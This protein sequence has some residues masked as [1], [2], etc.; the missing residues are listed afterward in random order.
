MSSC[1]PIRRA[2]GTP[3]AQPISP[4][5]SLRSSS[6]A[7]SF[8]SRT[9]ASTPSRRSSSAQAYAVTWTARIGCSGRRGTTV[10]GTRQRAALPAASV[11]SSSS[12]RGA[13][14]ARSSKAPCS[15]SSIRLPSCSSRAPGSIR[16]RS[17]RGRPALTTAGPP[18]S[19]VGAVVST[20]KRKVRS[21][22]VK[23]RPLRRTTSP[24]APSERFVGRTTARPF[25]T[26]GRT[27]RPSS[28]H[29]VPRAL[30]ANDSSVSAALPMRASCAGPV[31]VS[32]GPAAFA[33][34]PA[35]ATPSTATEATSTA[36]R[37]GRFR[38]RSTRARSVPPGGG[39][40]SSGSDGGSMRA[41]RRSSS[42]FSAQR[43]AIARPAARSSAISE[44]ARA[45]AQR[46][47]SWRLSLSIA[48]G[49]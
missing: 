29:S 42:S 49:E 8:R 45:A 35:P 48:S 39:D 17:S 32:S 20:V 38:L 10:T 37:H 13:G 18:T 6:T 24:W 11:A 7:F 12:L 26:L 33:A 22:L 40:P 36:R 30:D 23:K 5:S 28:S 15:S 3:E 31:T 16:P 41:R 14:D 34:T 43:V 1:A 47:S 19:S 27:G 4:D 44:R 25:R 21:A 2:S 9:S 46:S